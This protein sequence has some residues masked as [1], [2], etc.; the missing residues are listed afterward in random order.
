MTFFAPKNDS[1]VADKD[2]AETFDESGVTI[3]G[4]DVVAFQESLQIGNSG[5]TA[6]R[7]ADDGS[8]STNATRGIDF[9]PQTDLQGVSV[10]I[11]AN[12]QGITRIRLSTADSSPTEFDVV[13]GAFDAG[14]VVDLEADLNSSTKYSVVVDAEGSSY[15]LGEYGSA[16]PPYTSTDVNINEGRIYGSGTNGSTLWAIT[17]VTAVKTATS[18]GTA[19]IEWPDPPDVYAWD[20]AMFQRSLDSETVDVYI[21]EAQGS[22]GWT[23]VAGPISRGADIPADPANNVRFRV[24]ISRASSSNNPTLDA[25]YRRW[26]L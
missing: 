4:T 12:C 8:S 22:P 9:T 19:Y 15:T 18:P 2:R 23:E 26:K 21:E 7:P 3:S 17:D 5:S 10:T 6:D 25:V 11:S 13:T 16:S 20:T 14:D 24:E 1:V